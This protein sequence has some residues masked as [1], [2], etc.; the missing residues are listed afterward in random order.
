MIQVHSLHLHH[1]SRHYSHCRGVQ[2]QQHKHNA[3]I[4][5]C[6][7]DDVNANN[8]TTNDT[9]DTKK[10]SNSCRIKEPS[11]YVRCP[12]YPSFAY[13]G[14]GKGVTRRVS[15]IDAA[16]RKEDNDTVDEGLVSSSTTTTTPE[17]LFG[18]VSSLS[19]SSM[20]SSPSFI[21]SDFNFFRAKAK[22]RRLLDRRSYA[23]SVPFEK[24]NRY[25]PPTLDD[26]KP[27]PFPFIESIW[28]STPY[29]IATFALAY[30]L[31]PY[32]TGFLNSYT[33]MEPDLLSEIVSKFG[34]GVSV[35]YGT[36]ISLT[37]SILYG[38]QKD[39]QND[40]AV[41]S[42]LLALITRNLLNIFRCDRAL[43]IEVGQ[44]CADQIRILVKGSRGTELL[45]IMYSDPYARMLEIID[46][47]EYYL[48]TEKRR[49]ID[50]DLGGESVPLGSCRQILEDLYKIRAD[51]L[52]DESL[53]LP[54]T[55]FFIMTVLTGF[56]LLG[57]AIVSFHHQ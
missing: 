44:S 20:R 41:E 25:E 12:D 54:P 3:V 8:N 56:I 53:A 33:T 42:S 38:R 14:K 30:F 22:K 52:S 43:S 55:H 51:R 50:G 11:L 48:R 10:N 36:F 13:Y 47:R 15:L 35:L 5:D 29:R 19:S 7:C 46:D 21:E 40:V 24:E 31:F 49:D 28:I 9:N 17:Q 39:I 2:Q 45:A 16:K 4:G 26:L 57:Y 34:P 1:N 6:D 18:K 32:V 27:P 37:L 23:S